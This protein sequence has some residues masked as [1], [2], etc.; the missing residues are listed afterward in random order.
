MTLAVEDWGEPGAPRVVCLHGVTSH[1]RHFARFTAEAL[2]AF[3]V[4][5]PDLLGHGSSPYEPPWSIE[6]HLDAI[7]RTVGV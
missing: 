5:A 2:S 7:V 3:H 6:A 4:L 1:S